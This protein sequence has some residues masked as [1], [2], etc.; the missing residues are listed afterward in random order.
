MKGM[1]K[2][3]FAARVSNWAAIARTENL[4]CH[5]PGSTMDGQRGR[6]R[7]SCQE[8]TPL[9]EA[10]AAVGTATWAFMRGFGTIRRAAGPLAIFNSR[11]QQLVAALSWGGA[12]ILAAEGSVYS[13]LRLDDDPALATLNSRDPRRQF[14]VVLADSIRLFSSLLGFLLT[15]VLRELPT[16]AQR[17]RDR[18]WPGQDTCLCRG[19]SPTSS[20]CEDERRLTVRS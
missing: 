3:K 8:V 9:G 14:K 15:F 10:D 7:C 6:Q 12:Y 20:C 11:A 5:R 19:G 4:T 2:T 18:V 1:H 17:A 13:S 16:H